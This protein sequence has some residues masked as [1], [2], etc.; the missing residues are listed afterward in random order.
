MICRMPDYETGVFEEIKPNNPQYDLVDNTFEIQFRTTLSEGWHEVDHLM[1]YKCKPD[2]EPLVPL[3]LLF[4]NNVNDLY[5]VLR[6][7]QIYGTTD[8]NPAPQTEQEGARDFAS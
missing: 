8:Q 3:Q 6:Q 7:I 2:W 5:L 4:A 1:R